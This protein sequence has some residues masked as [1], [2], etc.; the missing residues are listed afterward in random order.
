[1]DGMKKGV[2][3]FLDAL[4]MKGVWNREA[5]FIDKWKR[6]Y[7]S[8]DKYSIV[9]EISVNSIFVHYFVNPYFPLQLNIKMESSI[10]TEIF[11]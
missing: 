5:N 9:S 7:N 3:V 8:F 1:M 10:I 2:V 4:G 6:V 11:R